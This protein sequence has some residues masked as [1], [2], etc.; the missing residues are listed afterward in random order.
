MVDQNA[1]RKLNG[2][3]AVWEALLHVH[4]IGLPG[5][6]VGLCKQLHSR[7][8]YLNMCTRPLPSERKV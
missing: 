7:V 8:A 3:G 4:V 6:N 1:G 5:C 2:G